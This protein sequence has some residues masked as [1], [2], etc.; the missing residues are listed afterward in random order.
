VNPLSP[1]EDQRSATTDTLSS[2]QHRLEDH[3]SRLYAQR[4]A[5]FPKQPV[6]ALEHGLTEQELSNLSNHVIEARPSDRHWL[7]WVVY[8]TEVGYEYSGEEYWQTFEE[9]TPRWATW[10]D[11]YWLRDCFWKFYKTYGG[12]RPS[13]AWARHFSIICWP[14]THAI[15]PRDLQRQLAEILYQIRHS[16]RKELFESPELLG[17]EIAARSWMATP[18][19]QMLT[20]EPLLLGQIAAALLIAEKDSS[21]SLIAPD[22]LVR[23]AKNLNRERGSREWLKDARSA[24]KARLTGLAPAISRQ[25]QPAPSNPHEQLQALGIEPRVYLRATPSLSWEVL[26]EIPDLAPL[27]SRFPSLSEALQGACVVAG[28]SG[29][30]LARGRLLHYGPQTVPLKRW[31]SPTDILLN[32]EKRPSELEFLLRTECMLRP[33]PAWLFKVSSDGIAREIRTQIVRPGNKYILLRSEHPA[34]EIEL[35]TARLECT[36][37]SAASI[38]VPPILSD[39]ELHDFIDLGLKPAQQVD[40]RPAGLPPVDWDGEGSAVW[41]SS[42]RARICISSDHPVY[43][44]TLNLESSAVAGRLDI[45]PNEPGER[46]FVELEELPPGDHTLHVFVKSSNDQILIGR[47]EIG[48]RDPHPWRAVLTDQNAFS[49][50]VDQLDPSLEEVWEGKAAFTIQGPPS[51]RADCKFSFSYLDSGKTIVVGKQLPPFALPVD[52]D[53]WHRY[54]E[55]YARS[56]K[57]FQDTYDLAENCKLHFSAEELGQYDFTCAREFSS[58]RWILRWENGGYVVRLKDD[59][60]DQN[61]LRLFRYE[62]LRP[63]LP[64]A[65]NIANPDQPTQVSEAGGLYSAQSGDACRSIVV[66]PVIHAL[67]DLRVRPVL[68]DRPRTAQSLAEIISAYQTWSDART[69]GDPLSSRRRADVLETL[70]KAIVERTCGSDWLASEL[71]LSQNQGSIVDLKSSISRK[72]FRAGFG[73]ALWLKHSELAQQSLSQRVTIFSQIAKSHLE[74]PGFAVI[75]SECK[76]LF[77]WTAEFTL[78]LFTRPETLGSWAANQFAGGLAYVLESPTL[79]RG[80]RFLALAVAFLG[81]TAKPRLTNPPNWDWP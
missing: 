41:L 37:V 16:F 49:V 36:G 1:S 22:T 43:E 12:A 61:G 45:L 57:S 59:T 69:A 39:K 72:A 60:G 77:Q 13:G 29:R 64:I 2:W 10:G 7:A 18:R 68:L 73:A 56:E 31:P 81:P 33:G 11:R 53:T 26:L 15:L 8:A 24:A 62:F 35:P 34:S 19:F 32:F 9:K 21:K 79:A 78:R 40:V 27:L 76:D 3:F 65:F 63:D 58:L 38:D 25:S 14:I 74:L 80:A 75:N 52:C 55:T 30:P 46:V 44:L 54:F 20:K 5:N 6:F 71:K 70:M 28:S 23:I 47:L 66:P 50:V 48:I 51:R 4:H 17:N 42:D 67:T